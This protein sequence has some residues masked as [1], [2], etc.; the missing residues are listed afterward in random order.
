MTGHGTIR[1]G[2]RKCEKAVAEIAKINESDRHARAY[3]QHK[4]GEHWNLIDSEARDAFTCC[5][6]SMLKCIAGFNQHGKRIK[7]MNKCNKKACC[8]MCGE[9]EDREH[10]I[11]CSQKKIVRDK[12]I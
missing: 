9:E 2:D 3:L 8:P 7:E 10:V 4:F 12:W 11:K 6:S 1:I 5:N